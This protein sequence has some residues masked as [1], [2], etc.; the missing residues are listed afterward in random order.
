M[1]AGCLKTFVSG[2]CLNIKLTDMKKIIALTGIL[3]MLALSSCSTGGA[4]RTAAKDETEQHAEAVMPVSTDGKVITLTDASQVLPVASVSQLTIL[5]FNAVWCGPC[6]QLTPVIDDLA[7]KYQG[8]ATFISIDVD[9]IG[10]LFEAY[11][12]GK[13]IPAVV[14][15][16]PGRNARIYIGTSDLLPA[17]RFDSI[18]SGFLN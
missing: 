3:S 15:L 10:D 7:K 12:L 5:D 17:E 1:V 8:R 16:P 11:N 14:I 2:Y 13:S 6:R 4:D 18:I 9:R